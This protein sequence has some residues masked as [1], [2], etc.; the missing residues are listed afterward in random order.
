MSSYI[1][2]VCVVEA[3]LRVR[4]MPA[5][6]SIIGRPM[7][8]RGGRGGKTFLYPLILSEREKISVWEGRLVCIT[9]FLRADG[10]NLGERSVFLKMK[11]YMGGRYWRR[12]L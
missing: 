11:G 4:C 5:K 9:V 10:Q 12:Y 6:K 7:T 3:I 1:L 8:G 2:R